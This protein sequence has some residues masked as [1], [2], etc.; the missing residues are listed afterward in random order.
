[1]IVSLSAIYN[2]MQYVTTILF[3]QVRGGKKHIRALLVDRIVLQHEVNIKR[4]SHISTY[5][6]SDYMQYRHIVKNWA[7]P[8]VWPNLP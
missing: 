6:L 8:K 2:S 4:L 5:N 1:M 3:L 7:L